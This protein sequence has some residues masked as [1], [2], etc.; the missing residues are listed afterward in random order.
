MN[1]LAFAITATALIAAV[2]VLAL[3][4]CPGIAFLLFLALCCLKADTK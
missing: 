1:H 2:V 3:H 4:D